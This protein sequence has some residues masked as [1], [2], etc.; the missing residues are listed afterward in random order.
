MASLFL[1]TPSGSGKVWVGYHA[2]MMNTLML[3]TQRGHDVEQSFRCG[4]SNVCLVRC[5]M[6]AEFMETGR[7][8]MLFIDDDMSWQAEDALKLI[9]SPHDVIG[10]IYPAKCNVERYNVLR[11][12]KTS[13]NLMQCEGLPGGFL[14]I[15]RKALVKIAKKFPELAFSF[16]D[17]KAHAFFDNAIVNGEYLTEDYAFTWRWLQCG[18][19]AFFYPDMKFGHYGSKAW[20]GNFLKD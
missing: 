1:A 11:P 12:S 5:L 19:K 8:V 3:L 9:E 18:G 20:H 13:T 14:K 15:T 6:A 10:G 2:S 4:N 7:D 17:M 16:N